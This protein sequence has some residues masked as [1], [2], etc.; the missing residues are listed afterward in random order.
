[1]FATFDDIWLDVFT[2][3][4]VLVFDIEVFQIKFS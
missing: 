1:M 2:G 4:N 3:T